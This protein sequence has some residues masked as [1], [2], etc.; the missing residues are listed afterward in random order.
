MVT[1]WKTGLCLAM[2]CISAK[3]ASIYH[4]NPQM[5]IKIRIMEEDSLKNRKP[6]VAGA[7]YPSDQ[8]ELIADLKEMFSAAVAR[9]KTEKI[10]AVIS[11]HAGYEYSGTVSAS[12]YNQLQTEK[13]YDNIFIIGTSHYATFEGA[14]IYC[15][16]YFDTP[17]GQARVNISLCRKLVDDFPDIFE[18]NPEIHIKEHS[19][20]VQIPFLQYLYKEKLQIIPIIIGAQKRNTILKISQALKPYF[21]GNNLFVIS[22]DFS[23]YPNYDDAKMI[24]QGTVDA[25]LSNSPDRFFDI[26]HEPTD[27]DIPNLATRICGWSSVLMLLN[28]TEGQ[29]IH[30]QPIHYMNSGDTPNSSKNRV[31]GYHAIIVASSGGEK[32]QADF[33]LTITEKQELLALARNTITSYLKNGK[34]PPCDTTGYSPRL[35]SRSGA[36]V[37]I[38]K[39]NELRGCIGNFD[40]GMPLYRT[41]QEEAV[42][43]ATKD[44]RFSSITTEETD[45]IDIEISVLTPM[46][47]IQ[48]IQEIVPG[49]HGIYMKKGNKSGTFLPQVADQT[50]WSIA[51]LLGHC[52]RDKAGIGW[53]GWKDAEIYIYE[54]LIFSEKDFKQE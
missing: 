29:N 19:L 35:M 21:G 10:V 8:V 36:F 48:S 46:Q 13:P 3:N 26:L 37:T 39:N 32:K 24:D 52:A 53:D 54:A 17:I 20:E 44:Y 18:N 12:A 5:I 41:I 28:I 22:T 50:G 7:F 40:S 27:H 6:A 38:H 11:P 49:R 15:N 9:K 25:I 51:E 30:I 34:I 16:G 4:Q 31:V 42:S 43:A 23:H 45:E 2:L 33:E 14:S 47:K 1:K